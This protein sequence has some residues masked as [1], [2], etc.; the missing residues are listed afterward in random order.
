MALRDAD[1]GEEAIIALRIQIDADARIDAVAQIERPLS[2]H[3]SPARL[4]RSR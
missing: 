2:P 3:G 1:D 4:T